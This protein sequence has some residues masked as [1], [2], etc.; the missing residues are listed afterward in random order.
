MPVCMLVLLIYM[1]RICWCFLARTFRSFLRAI[2]MKATRAEGPLGSTI[3]LLDRVLLKKIKK[4]K[5]KAYFY[6]KI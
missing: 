1:P 2:Y 4:S 3:V 5:Q 6:K